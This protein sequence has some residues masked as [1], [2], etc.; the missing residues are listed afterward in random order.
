[1]QRKGMHVVQEPGEIKRRKVKSVII[2]I[3]PNF[4]WVSTKDLFLMFEQIDEDIDYR[5]FI[6]QFY[7]AFNDGHFHRKIDD[8]GRRSNAVLFL[9]K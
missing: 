8:G 5:S 1:M 4:C 6:T 2:K 7:D 9:K 3:M